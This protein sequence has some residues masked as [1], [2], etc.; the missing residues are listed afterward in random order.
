MTA[1]VEVKFDGTNWTDITSRVTR[2]QVRRGRSRQLDTITAGSCVVDVLNNDGELDPNKASGAWFGDLVPQREIRVRFDRGDGTDVDVFVGRIEDLDYEY[3][4]FGKFGRARLMATDGLAR[5]AATALSA[6]TPSAQLSGARVTA[7][8]NRSEVNYPGGAARSIDTGLSTLGAF[9]VT[10]GTNTLSYLQSVAE[11]EQGR[12]FVDRSGVLQFVDR[13]ATYVTS[14]AWTLSDQTSASKVPYRSLRAE[15]GSE[16][17]F[18]RLEVT[19]QS[20][21]TQTATDATSISDYGTRTLRLD[22]V[23]VSTDAQ[24]L[25]LAQWLVGFYGE[26]EYRIAEVELDWARVPSGVRSAASVVDIAQVVNLEFTPPGADPLAVALIVEGVEHSFTP[27]QH[28]VRLSL[29]A[30]DGRAFLT[31]DDDT[32]GLLDSNLL[33]F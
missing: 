28:I 32:F 14:G 24:A 25:A 3:Q 23:L 16:L 4:E 12:L 20:G 17:L 6:H 30:T 19:R 11:A 33:A 1:T 22:G 5:L 21:A 18:N 8:L 31:L 7:V 9:A 26:P 15:Y 29:G 27:S 10:A 2:V 13:D